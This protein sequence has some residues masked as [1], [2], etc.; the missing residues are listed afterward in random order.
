MG[1]R[2]HNPNLVKLNYTYTIAEI[3]ELFGVHQGTVRRWIKEGLPLCGEGRPM[4]VLGPVLKEFIA[5]RRRKARKP[6]GPGE[7]YCLKCRRPRR[8]AGDIAD[9]QL[10]RAGAG[11]LVAICSVCESM[12]YQRAGF[13][14]LARVR[15]EVT[16]T[17]VNVDQRLNEHD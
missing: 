11:L 2:R 6:C 4:L 13:S 15:G 10:S 12:I 16:I 3:A 5:E 8:P 9:Y 1:N 17:M 7:M 14:T